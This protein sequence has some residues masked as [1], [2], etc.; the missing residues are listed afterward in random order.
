MMSRNCSY[1]KGT[2]EQR[3]VFVSSWT[4][5]RHGA[6]EFFLQSPVQ[7]PQLVD[8]RVFLFQHL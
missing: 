7:V 4:I 3:V 8:A 6:Q 1:E 2:Q 5:R